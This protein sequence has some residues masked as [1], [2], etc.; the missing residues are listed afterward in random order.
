[1]TKPS[2]TPRTC[3]VRRR[4]AGGKPAQGWLLQRLGRKVRRPDVRRLRIGESDARLT[5]V[6][7]LV[8]FNAFVREQGVHREL[9]HRFGHLK[10]GR[11]VVYPMS[12]QLQLLIDASVA[13]AH[14][15][16]D[17]EMLA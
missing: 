10:T 14:R 2:D 7:G 6:G 8:S 12:A 9:G 11:R 5:T 16:F 13:G 15:V 1:M 4:S 17:M 3:K